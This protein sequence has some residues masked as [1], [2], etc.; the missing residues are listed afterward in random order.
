MPLVKAFYN[1]QIRGSCQT[2]EEAN[3]KK[4]LLDKLSATA[5]AT[6]STSR[7]RLVGDDGRG[8]GDIDESDT[9]SIDAISDI[10]DTNSNSI[11]VYLELED[12]SKDIPLQKVVFS[13]EG[14][15]L[16]DELCLR[17]DINQRYANVLPQWTDVAHLLE[18]DSLRTK[19]VETCV[20]PR[21]GLTR[22]MLEIYMN[23]GG[24][25]G[26]VLGALIKLECY[27]ILETIRPKA[28]RYI[29]HHRMGSKFDPTTSST[30]SSPDAVNEKFFSVLKT[31]VNVLG[32]G[33][34]CDELQKF[35]YG[36][37]QLQFS[38]CLPQRP[39][40]TT[41]H[42]VGIVKNSGNSFDP[43][44]PF[45]QAYRS[46]LHL[47]QLKGQGD[48][49]VSAPDSG[50]KSKC[51][52]LLIFSRD[53]VDAADEFVRIA[54]TVEH[55]E[56]VP[57][58]FRLNEVSLWYEV[59]TD[60]QGC[61]LKWAYEAD[62][63]MP[64]LTP[65]FLQEIHCN[66]GSNLNQQESADEGLLPTSPMLNRYLYILARSQY[67]QAGSKNLKVRPLIP[68]TVLRQ[69][70]MS[71]AVK[72]DPLLNSSWAPLNEERVKRRLNGMLK[73]WLRRQQLS[74]PSQ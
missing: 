18:V 2:E 22:A 72:I 69:V 59:L 25:L 73:E 9:D 30:N 4:K 36:L 55:S 35:K 67:T 51:K 20:R 26:D 10:E 44:K 45:E 13:P 3:L 53:G 33:D 21:E 64:V 68:P 31:L 28:E 17:V 8:G 5:S 42:H 32:S 57:D 62:Y 14:M 39:T 58:V 46:D 38:S 15:A 50:G 65:M 56:V 29:E 24:T 70:R 19:W 37:K 11:R 34:P 48:G 60:P 23:D 66:S 16:F 6:S 41:V 40:E 43:T 12:H 1:G 27:D 74:R 47:E 52:I 49:G 61:C 7:D 54:S 63:I 71:N